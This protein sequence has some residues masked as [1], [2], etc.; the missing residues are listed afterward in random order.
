MVFP[1]R[2][3][4]WALIKQTEWKPFLDLLSPSF[5][6]VVPAGPLLA[7]LRRLAALYRNA[8]IFERAVT[9]RSA[10]LASARLPIEVTAAKR[11]DTPPKPMDAAAARARGQRILE[12]YFH[13]IFDDG[14]TLLDLRQG[15]F[16][17]PEAGDGALLWSPSG[18]LGDWSPEFRGA[19]RAL[20]RG[21]YNGDDRLFREGLSALGLAK[22]EEALRAQFG[23]GQQREVHFTLRDFQQK[24]QE[25]FVRC[26]ATGSTIDTGFLALGLYLATLYEHLEALAQPFDARAA[27]EVATARAP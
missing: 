3:M 11:A 5:F 10:S 16:T 17:Q 6:R 4:F 23:E 8:D 19:V 2:L 26:Q 22:A 25:V 27:F 1:S 13:Q 18:A 24:F 15:R 14:L 12:L 20:Y 7:E 9:R 21:F